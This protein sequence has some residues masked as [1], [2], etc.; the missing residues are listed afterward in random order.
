M[1]KSN[2]VRYFKTSPEVIRLSVKLCERFPL[3]L[4]N[5]EDMRTNGA[6]VLATKLPDTD[7]PNLV[8][9]LLLKSVESELAGC[10]PARIGNGI[11]TQA[12][13]PGRE[14]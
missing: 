4:R 12:E 11:W 5:V 3:S 13:Q 7:G 8:H 14:F 2:L 6:S 1:K 9:C 10:D